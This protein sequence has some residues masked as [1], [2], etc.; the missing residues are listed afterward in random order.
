STADESAS[1]APTTGASSPRLF[2][3]GMAAFLIIVVLL[4][5]G[6]TYGRQLVFGLEISGQGVVETD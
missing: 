2:W 5:F 3:V 6:S 4:G 1:A